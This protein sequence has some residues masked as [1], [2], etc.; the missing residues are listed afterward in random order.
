MLSKFKK[1]IVCELNNGQFVKILQSEFPQFDYLKYN[2]IQGL[3]F[4]KGQLIN[5]FD[6]LIGA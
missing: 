1:I 6:N 3:P 5:E 2:K 4:S